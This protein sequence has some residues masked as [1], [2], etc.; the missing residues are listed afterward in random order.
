MVEMSQSDE[1]PMMTARVDCHP[2]FRK[3][4][5]SR[6]HSAAVFLVHHCDLFKSLVA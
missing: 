5:T 6:K 2:L 1:A 3:Q 4:Q